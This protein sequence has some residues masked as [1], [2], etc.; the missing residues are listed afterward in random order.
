MLVV[1]IDEWRF[2]LNSLLGYKIVYRRD[3]TTSLLHLVRA[4]NIADNVVRQERQF[5]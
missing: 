5:A 3:V 1:H 2:Q 4:E